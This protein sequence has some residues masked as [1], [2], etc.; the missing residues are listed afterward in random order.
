MKKTSEGT[1]P[2]RKAHRPGTQKKPQTR[3]RK[4]RTAPIHP[5]EP[6]AEA[7]LYRPARRFQADGQ[8]PYPVHLDDDK[9]LS[10]EEKSE[11]S[12]T[13]QVHRRKQGT[14]QVHRNQIVISSVESVPL[15][16]CKKPSKED[17]KKTGEQESNKMKAQQSPPQ[18]DEQAIT[19]AREQASE[20]KNKKACKQESKTYVAALTPACNA[21]SRSCTCGRA[22]S[23]DQD[24]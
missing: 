7:K 1:I 8:S 21:V 23:G 10:G 15:R 14:L 13:F 9:R 5:Q 6:T 17:S 12:G 16:T 22:H 11:D 20:Q 18:Y 2:P 19:R 24:A 3:K 4:S